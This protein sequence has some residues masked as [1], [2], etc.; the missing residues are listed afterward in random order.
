MWNLTLHRWIGDRS[1]AIEQYIEAHLAWMSEQM[2]AG[3]I[4]LAGPSTDLEVGVVVIKDMPPAEVEALLRTEP[5]VAN[6]YRQFE[7]IRWDV[8]QIFGVDAS[9]RS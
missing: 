8:H 9:P 6:G 3:T 5:F 7:L 2:Q 1:E 4:L